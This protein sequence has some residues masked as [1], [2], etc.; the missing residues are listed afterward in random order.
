MY[1]IPSKKKKSVTG[2][3]LLSFNPFTDSIFIEFYVVFIFYLQ[4]SLNSNVNLLA[5]KIIIF[6]FPITTRSD[7]L[8]LLQFKNRIK[9]RMN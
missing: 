7:F 9:A 2:I 1:Y 6:K 5:V 4:P 8:T 3:L